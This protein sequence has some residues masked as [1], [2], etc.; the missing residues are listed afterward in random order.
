MALQCIGKIASADDV[1]WLADLYASTRP[2]DARA[3]IA[4]AIGSVAQP[5]ASA[6]L[7]D[8]IEREPYYFVRHSLYASLAR[9]LESQWAARTADAVR[10][11]ES[12]NPDHAIAALKQLADDVS[13]A[14][15]MNYL[16]R[17][18]LGLISLTVADLETA[19]NK[20][21]TLIIEDYRK[22]T[23][24][25]PDSTLA[26]ADAL[27]GLAY[28]LA[29]E[30]ADMEEAERAARKALDI[31]ARRSTAKQP[32]DD[33]H[34]LDTLALVLFKRGKL[35]E[36]KQT[37]SLCV[38]RQAGQSLEIHDHLGDILWALQE[39][40]AARAAWQKALTLESDT[41]TDKQRAKQVREKLA[42]R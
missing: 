26:M 40:D 41:S 22:A 23:V 30:T 37:S 2:F 15:A 33:T 29:S 39:H 19:A 20:A 24:D 3:N 36:A 14:P 35:E 6:M 25:L 4:A 7:A 13:K 32:L 42:R 34:V 11:G 10:N 1:A 8:W 17:R 28:A 31:F 38:S 18:T 12:G 27:N 16:R 5:N 21:P 9:S